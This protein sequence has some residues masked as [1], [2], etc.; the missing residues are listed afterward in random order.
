MRTVVLFLPGSTPLV[1]ELSPLLALITAGL[2]AFGMMKSL[3][4]FHHR[5]DDEL[6]EAFF[7]LAV[8]NTDGYILDWASRTRRLKDHMQPNVT[9]EEF[10]GLDVGTQRTI[11]L[12]TESLSWN[13]LLRVNRDAKSIIDPNS[14]IWVILLISPLILCLTALFVVRVYPEMRK[15]DQNI[16]EKAAIRFAEVLGTTLLAI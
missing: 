11:H 15:W 14:S 5:I 1:A 12:K 4:V 9:A 7:R 13:R 6:L 10:H 2:R 8:Q 3:V 16:S